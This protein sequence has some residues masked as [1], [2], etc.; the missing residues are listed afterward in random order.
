MS[1]AMK[2]DVP[3]AANHV[4]APPSGAEARCKLRGD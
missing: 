3:Q 2:A 4:P 1:D